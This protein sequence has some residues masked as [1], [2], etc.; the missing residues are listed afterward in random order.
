MPTTVGGVR[1]DPGGRSLAVDITTNGT[2]RP[3]AYTAQNGVTAHSLPVT[4]STITEFWFTQPTPA[5]F[6]AKLSGVEIAGQGGST[7][8]FYIS[9]TN[10]IQVLTPVVDAIEALSVNPGGAGGVSSVNGQ[11]SAVTLTAD[12]IAATPYNT[13]QGTLIATQLA[14]LSDEKLDQSTVNLAYLQT[15]G[16]AQG[17]AAAATGDTGSITLDLANGQLQCRLMSGNPAYTLPNVNS[18][19]TD[20]SL[21][22]I[23]SGSGGN[24]PSF[25]AAS[26]ETIVWEGG[27]AP[28]WDTTA[29][30]ITLAEFVPDFARLRWVGC[31]T[32]ISAGSDNDS[33]LDYSTSS[34]QSTGPVNTASET[35]LY[36]KALPA[37]AVGNHLRLVLAGTGSNNSGTQNVVIKVK[38]GSTTVM[39]GNN[40]GYAASATRFG[41]QMILDMIVEASSTT[42]FALQ[43]SQMSPAATGMSIPAN[44]ANVLLGAF[45]GATTAEDVSTSKTL[46]VTATLSGAVSSVDYK[47]EV[48]VL[49]VIV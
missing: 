46:A 3:T 18:K 24:T 9:P 40:Q 25:V 13:L 37:L 35:N 33:V 5:I 38:I 31:A 11:T 27:T 12:N 48:H 4:I 44:N 34:T 22:L 14:E 43:F 49:D 10:Q 42:G 8:G 19:G 7:V 45:K 17:G 39:T 15:K 2:V 23:Q 6:S 41:W 30:G 36:S 28:T 21:M 32:R 1:V 16:A 20:V 26:G 47:C 29:D